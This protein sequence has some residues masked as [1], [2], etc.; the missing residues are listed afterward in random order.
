[1][2]STESPWIINTTDETFEADCIQRS[3]ELPV[4]IDFWA[5]WCAPCRRLAPL[6]EKLAVEYDGQFLLVK[7]NTEDTPGAST[8]FGVSSIPAVFA[9]RHGQLVNQFKGLLP[10]PELRRWLD[11]LL[12]SE[13]ERLVS[14]ADALVTADPASAEAKYRQAAEMDTA[15]VQA[16]E[17]LARLLLSQNRVDEVHA[18]IDPLAERGLLSSDG[19]EL[20]A[21]LALSEQ[22]DPSIGL[23]ELRLSVEQNPKDLAVRLEFAGALGRAGKHEE[24]L[25]QALSI[26]E[27]DPE[28]Y[29]GQA[30]ELMVNL[31]QILGEDSPL[32][33]Q[34]RRKLSRAL[35]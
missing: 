6:L 33:T 7:A 28:S 16:Q 30:R 18:L 17:R 12:P 31:F 14:E 27:D 2:S 4:V 13:A 32:V 11:T 10:E 5:E 15:L 19:E 23:D 35:Y 21:E 25:A 24:A 26:V 3:R 1:M 8:A 34:Y 29:G 22:G 20:K 9:L